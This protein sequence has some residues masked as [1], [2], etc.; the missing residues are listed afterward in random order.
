[1]SGAVQLAEHEFGKPRLLGTVWL[2]DMNLEGNVPAW[3]SGT[4]LLAGAASMGAVCANAR[5]CGDADARAW[6]GLAILLGA[7]SLDEVAGIHEA[8]GAVLGGPDDPFVFLLPGTLLLLVVVILVAGFVRRLPT[9]TGNLLKLGAGVWAF[10]S[11]IL[12]LVQA[13]SHDVDGLAGALLGTAQD[14]FELA[15]V[16]IVLHAVLHYYCVRAYA[17]TVTFR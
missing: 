17:T 6:G 5:G 7:A 10:G 3:F 9:R 14:T 2:F 11:V 8:I 12:E 13:A 16:I 4:L 1:M 15:G